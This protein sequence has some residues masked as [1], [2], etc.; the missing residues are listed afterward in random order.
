MDDFQS[1]GVRGILSW[2]EGEGHLG[3]TSSL[4]ALLLSLP[5]LGRRSLEDLSTHGCVVAGDRTRMWKIL[6]S[7]SLC[8]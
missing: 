7:T 3:E 1:W 4:C 6:P 8:H 2:G 5:L